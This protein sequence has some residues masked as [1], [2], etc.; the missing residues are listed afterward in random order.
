M[1]LI[2]D[3]MPTSLLPLHAESIF[4]GLFLISIK[5]FAIGEA[6]TGVLSEYF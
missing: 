6:I 3:G 2:L 4:T 5:L 1:F